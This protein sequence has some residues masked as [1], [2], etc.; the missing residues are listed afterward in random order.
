[1]VRVIPKIAMVV[2]CCLF[3]FCSKKQTESTN[4]APYVIEN[5]VVIVG[6]DSSLKSRL[7]I[8][9]VL[10]E[11][12]SF[13]LVTAGIV[14]AIPNQYAEIAS[15]FSGRILKSYV[16]LGQKVAIGTPLFE[17][18][19]LDFYQTQKDYFDSQQEYKQ[20][21][22]DL[23][24]Q[25][26][27]LE[28]G[29]GIRQEY[30]QA[31]TQNSIAKLAF[32]N[33]RA[34]M[35]IYNVDTSNLVLGQALVVTSPIN[36]E[37]IQDDIVIGQYIQEDAE[38]IMK[39]ASLEN[40]WV[41]GKI[42]EKDLLHLN[43]LDKVQVELAAFPDD[44]IQGQIYHI[45]EI[46]D[47]Q[48]RSIDVLIQVHNTQRLLR[49]GMYVNVRFKDKPQPVLLIPTSSIMQAE[50]RAFVYV[51]VAPFE[52]VIKNVEIGGVKGNQSVITTGLQPGDKVV[53]EGGIYLPKL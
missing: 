52:F 30:E 50:N 18:S 5:N 2:L 14:K 37:V 38:P 36:G 49:P 19:S 48:T 16:R 31:Q 47:E 41:V 39:I 15:P 29:V 4:V 44:P 9:Q 7:K 6:E 35:A 11:D 1:M 21:V 25:A 45:N 23:N 13:D 40:I 24:R 43:Q 42:K 46:V 8:T 17:V 12:F 3:V 10:P 22:L 32:D 27:L 33:A 53:S 28:N 34:A 51:E 20:S 26:D